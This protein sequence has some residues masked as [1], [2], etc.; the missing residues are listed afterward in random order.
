MAP[1]PRCQP[2]GQRG[3]GTG[4]YDTEPLPGHYPVSMGL[5]L[6]KESRLN[7]LGKRA[8]QWLYWNRLLPGRD[9]PGIGSAMPRRGKTHQHA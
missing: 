9:L 6:L 7:H 3:T 2:G 5:P 8:F 4:A 1:A